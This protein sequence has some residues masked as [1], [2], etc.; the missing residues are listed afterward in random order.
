MWLYQLLIMR[1]CIGI[2]VKSL[3]GLLHQ[4]S[5]WLYQLLVMRLCIGISVKSLSGLLHKCKNAGLLRK[6]GLI[7]DVALRNPYFYLWAEL[8]ITWLFCGRL[9]PGVTQVGRHSQNQLS[10]V[11]PTNPCLISRWHASVEFHVE[12]LNG[13]NYPLFSV[14]DYS[15]NGTYVNDRRVWAVA[16]LV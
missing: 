11:S 4:F 6:H 16:V 8:L 7:A 13:I 3:S 14:T 12:V 5:M 1:L 2:S 15:L 10:L 9:S